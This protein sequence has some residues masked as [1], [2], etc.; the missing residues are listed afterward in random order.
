MQLELIISIETNNF[1]MHEFN[2]GRVSIASVRAI[3]EQ[4]RNKGRPQVLGFRYDLATQRELIGMNSETLHLAG[5]NSFTKMKLLSVLAAWKVLAKEVS[6]RTFC[7][8]DSAVK[9]HLH[10]AEKV[11]ELVHASDDSMLAFQEMRTRIVTE[12]YKVQRLEN[13]REDWNGVERSWSPSKH[14][15]ERF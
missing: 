3:V 10:D 9:K 6:V 11:L 1:L 4:W 8:P 5:I 15:S 12:I 13:E 2:Q 7:Q 14:H